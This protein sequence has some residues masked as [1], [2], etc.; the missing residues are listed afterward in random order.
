LP[1]SSIGA[2]AR[3]QGPDQR[4]GVLFELGVEEVSSPV[5]DRREAALLLIVIDVDQRV[6]ACDQR[7]PFAD[8]RNVES[9]GL[10][11]GLRFEPL[12]DRS[13]SP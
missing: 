13:Q 4:L 10:L 6:K 11:K 1:W 2:P 7:A 3:R 8:A 5:I 12:T 9:V